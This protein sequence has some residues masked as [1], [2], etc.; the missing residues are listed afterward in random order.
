[1]TPRIA[2]AAAAA[3]LAL[4]GCSQKGP[5]T[6]APQISEHVFGLTPG[7][8]KVKS[9]IVGGELSGMKVTERV[10]EGSGRVDYGPKLSGRLVLRNLSTDKSVLIDGG[11]LV[12]ADAADKP[13]AM[14][15]EATPPSIRL[16]DSYNSTSARLDPGQELT[17]DID[18]DFPADALKPGQLRE[19]RVQLRYTAAPFR[20]DL[21]EFPVTL[22]K[23]QG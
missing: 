20:R 15:P 13:I 16:G 9:G 12:F 4:A 19:I 2:L 7:S 23:K 22:S 1:M 17:R 14:P 18:V 21:L 5:E 3:A 10:E 8:I 6:A 11:K